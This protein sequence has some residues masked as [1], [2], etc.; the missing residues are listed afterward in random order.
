[1]LVVRGVALALFGAETADRRAGFDDRSRLLTGGSGE[2]QPSP[3]LT[4]FEH[5]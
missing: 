2:V 1:M 4:L 3:C 5:E